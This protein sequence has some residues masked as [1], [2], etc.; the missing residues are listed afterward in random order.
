MALSVEHETL[1]SLFSDGRILL[2]LLGAAGWR[3]L[4]QAT[5]EARSASF[6]EIQPAP[7]AADLVFA[8]RPPGDEQE[9]VFVIEILLGNVARKRRVLP[10]YVASAFARTRCLADL[11]IVTLDAETE[12]RARRPV[13]VGHGMKL[14]PIVLGRSVIPKLTDPDDARARPELAVLSALAHAHAPEAPSIGLCA[15]AAAS[16]LD[17]DHMRFYADIVLHALPAAARHALE[18]LMNSQP[19]VYRSEFAQRYI[20]VGRAEGRHE[21]LALAVLEI[22]RAR[23]LPVTESDRQRISSI[24]DEATLRHL[25]ER[26]ATASRSDDLWA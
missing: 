3:D 21:G 8:I 17:D 1:V 20:A 4:R 23:S 11:V 24:T 25:L 9:H 26:A 16:T 2:D 10:L 15:L 7:Y 12:R 13:V 6:A 19:Y 18:V 5:V 14:R 22:L